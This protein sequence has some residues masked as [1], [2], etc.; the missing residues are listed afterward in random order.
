M[1]KH[2]LVDGCF[3]KGASDA[4]IY[5]GQSETVIVKNSIADNNVA[6]IEI[7]NTKHADVFNCTAINNTG[8]IVIFDLPGLPAGQGN[9]TRLFNCTIENNNYKNFAPEGNIVGQVPP[10]T[11]IM[12]MASENVEVFD[13]II[14]NNNLMSIGLVDYQVLA[15]FSGRTVDDESYITYPRDISIHNNTI[16]R[17]N[18]CPSELNEIGTILKS[19][20]EDCEIPEI[21]WDGITA[22]D[23]LTEEMS[24]CIQSSGSVI[25]LDLGN[26]P[27]N[28]EIK[29][30]IQHFNCSDK[31]ALPEVT[32]LAPTL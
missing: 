18:E 26:W 25:D 15:T 14:T 9:T 10:G 5:V 1:C 21:L 22:L 16:S 17:K 12:L 32:V 30:D 6:G 27:L 7:E 23:K 29:A 13:N 3:A 28:Q 2:L 31:D 8:G 19:F 4:G 11:G 20:F 24:I